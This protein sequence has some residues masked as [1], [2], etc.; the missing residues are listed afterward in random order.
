MELI[1]I[2][3]DVGRPD[4]AALRIDGYDYPVTVTSPFETEKLGELDWYFEQHLQFPFTDQVR[5]RHAGQSITAYGEAL[6]KQLFASDEAREA[7]GALKKRAF[8]DQ[9]GIAVI[10]SPAFQGLHWEALKDPKLPR[11]FA[12]DVP[13]MRRR[14]ASAPVIEAVA[15]NSPTLN[16]LVLTARPG[17]ARDV[18]YRTITRPLVG[19]L[20]QAQL[21]VDVDFVRPGTWQALV[22][23][24]EAV[25]RD[26]G[27]GYYHAVH[28]D[29]HGGLLTY[30]EFAKSLEAPPRADRLTL[31]GRWGR[32]EIAPYEG[33]KAFL[34]FQPTKDDPSGLG[35]AKELAELLLKHKIPIAIL[36]A[37]QSGKQVGAEESSLAAR[38][39]EAGMQSALGM[40]WS[41]TVSAAERLIPKLYGDLFAGQ[42][43]GSAV[44]AGRRELAAD[45]ARRAAFNET[46]ELEDWLLPVVYQN[47]EP[48]L[49][50]REFTSEEVTRWYAA[51]AERSP[52]PVTEY[53]FF[54]RDL[55]VLR[56]ETALLMR[57]NLLL[58]QGMGGSGKSTLFRHL[59][60]WW[61]LTGFTERTFYF[62]W[63]EQAWTRAQ[64]MRKLASK[65]LAADIVRAFDTMAEAAQ[66]QAVA[67]ALRSKRHLLILDNLES[68]T[69]APLAIPHSLNTTQRDELR[70]FLAA[71][72]GG[73]TLVLLGS[74]GDEAWL[75][76]DTF[77][78]NVYQLKGLD[79]EAA[80]DLADA[81]LQQAGAQ[82]RRAESAFKELM[83]LLA[84]YPLAL[85][86]VLP[87]LA[88]KA[89]A[90][91]LEELRQGLAE[92]DAAAG[93]DP[94]V[95]R[96]RTLMACIDYSH[97]HLDPDDQ[98]L[99]ICFAPFTGVIN[100]RLL[101]DYQQA[102]ANEPVLAGLPL[103]RLG[104]VLERARGLGLLQRD[105]QIEALLHPQPALSWFLTG[106][107]GA[108]DQA[109]RRAAIERA[110]REHYDNFAR[111][112]YQLQ[113]SN[114]PEERR[115]ARMLVEQEYANLG[116]ALRFALD[117][118]TSMLVPY[119]VLS[120]HL[121]YLQDHRRGRELAELV[122]DKLEQL[123]PDAV[124]GRRGAEFAAVIDDIAK[125]QL[126]LRELDSARASYE[127][128]L[129][130]H[131]GLEGLEPRAVAIG[132]AGILHQL[133]AVA[134]VQRRY[135]EAEDAYNK[136]LAIKLE[137]NDRHGAAGTYHQLG[138]VAEEQRRF[139]EAEDAYKKALAIK[140]E[141]ND[142]HSAAST[143]HQ[144]GRVAEEQRRF[145][146]AEDVYKKA[147]EIY[148]E[149]SDRY[150]QAGTYLQLGNMALDQHR[151]AEAE[152]AYKTALAIF[153]EFNDRHG[154]A[155]TYHQL[156][157]VAED[158]RRFADAEDAYKKALE[159][160]LE[161]ND[162]YGA[163][164]TY[165][166]TGIVAQE[167]RRFAEA[168][169]AY[170]MALAIKLEFNDRHSAASTYHQLGRVAEEQRRFAEAEDAY[171][172]ALEIYVEFNDAH[173]GGIVLRSLAWVWRQTGATSIPGAVATI[174]K[175]E[176]EQATELLEQL[177]KTA[178]DPPA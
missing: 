172:K 100:T 156:G 29:L 147:L 76:K 170:K 143:Y 125:R 158:Q 62:G 153:V 63:D 44:L 121:D 144:L 38:L 115:L 8:P 136:A 35:E 139:A 28:F 27:A 77:A 92:V 134:Q 24:L 80:S 157:M 168:E 126:Q 7:Y 3:E 155:R 141:F 72:S 95:A 65:V 83:A 105:A 142:R 85:Q 160:K 118:Q 131:D 120:G 173:S 174:F 132:R 1:E 128:A 17:E 41:V 89:V 109:E 49:A 10:G 51:A 11:P 20:R 48:R 138:R 146:E 102:L 140:L 64:I 98:A 78:D 103:E 47:R 52:E 117:Q 13:I 57:R 122:L 68:V 87:H 32:G 165:H 86:V 84:G 50:F 178:P 111:T 154:A 101:E 148:A 133:G 40:A 162:R 164:S 36:N 12:L 31:R 177:G 175:V 93:S 116:R 163:A 33:R 88:A 81:V 90:K 108:A 152:D 79:P 18:G 104:A 94:V 5:A 97:G 66:Q 42:P 26:R 127:K 149:F 119:T 151:L 107:L 37:C 169:D 99:L 137:F 58:V 9:L 75:A 96:T 114:K 73:Q 45:K 21:R 19:T 15:A 46:I 135:P 129:A 130:I 54:G 69:A 43:L 176:T 61:E 150:E 53:G 55:D 106:R 30:E 171:N 39:L 112:L 91:V 82:S 16:L 124:T 161:F 34:C 23:R 4:G 56:I 71:L 67:A 123:P 59:A 145:A 2:R 70:S 14:R 22:E 6:F 110:F 167:Q 159:I 60:H 25:T 113:Q 166:Q 74:R